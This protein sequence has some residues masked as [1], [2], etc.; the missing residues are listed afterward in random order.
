MEKLYKIV[1]GITIEFS[2][3]DYKEQADN[4]ARA[5]TELF[6]TLKSELLSKR[7]A[8]LSTTDWYVTRKIKRG[9]EIPQEILDKEVLCA[10]EIDLIKLCKTLKQLQKFDI[11]YN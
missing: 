4:Q 9:V 11:N 6:S 5:E 1:N 8:Y 10:K 7:I 2:D 3:A